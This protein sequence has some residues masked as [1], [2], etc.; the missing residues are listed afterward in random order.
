[1]GIIINKI[2]VPLK[3]SEVSKSCE[4]GYSNIVRKLSEAKEIAAESIKIAELNRETQCVY[5][6]FL[7]LTLSK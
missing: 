6:G 3:T 2:D 7:T 4:E 1:M 5:A